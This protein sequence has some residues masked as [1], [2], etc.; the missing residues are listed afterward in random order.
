MNEEE[1][2][3]IRRRI[4]LLSRLSGDRPLVYMDN[5]A[6]APTPDRVIEAVA[7]YYRNYSC[8]IHRG[9]YE[10]SSTATERYERSRRRIAAFLGADSEEIVYTPGAT[11]AVNLVAE[12]WGANN[13]KPG[14]AVAVSELEHHANLI[15]WQRLT[16]RTGTELRFL[17][18]DPATGELREEEIPH[19]IDEKVKLVAV[20]A[21]S[22][23]TGVITPLRAIAAAARRAGATLLVDAAQHA[24]HRRIDVR[25][26][27]ADF[28][29]FS[30]HKLFGPTGL[31]ILFGRRELLQQMPP[32][33]TGGDMITRVGKR[34][35]DFQEPPQRFEA[36]TPH[37]A[38]VF[39]AEA[40]VDFLEEI[41]RQRIEEREE[42]LLRYALQRLEETPGLV[43]YGPRD[44]R[45]GAVCSFNLEGIHAHDTATILA[46]QGIAV[47]AG[48]H[49]AQPYV[50]RLGAQGTV[51]ASL[52][53]FNTEEEI[54]YL[55]EALS[56]VRRIFAA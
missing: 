46:E 32:F 2:R 35:A 44:P 1:L 49:C 9:L 24:V 19:V 12:S 27:D 17:P 36:G 7:D 8:N 26:M 56:E 34:E 4:P 52:A 38:G 42:V 23:V 39:G 37:I 50:E 53:F 41:G 30:L 11:A 28:L 20:S 40:A 54:D 13:L 29:V 14:D 47:R 16:A 43:L 55:I 18:V 21:M 5:A 51:R 3:E 6:S 22:N 48:F 25:E 15:P 33:L 10:L 45:Q 31:G